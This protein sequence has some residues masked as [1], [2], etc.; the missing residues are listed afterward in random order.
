MIVT[1]PK[2]EQCSRC[3][4]D[5]TDIVVRIT[6]PEYNDILLHERCE[7]YFIMDMSLREIWNED[8]YPITY[9]TRKQV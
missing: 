1:H 9:L 5:I 6:S 8:I 7:K 3:N 4:L 2:Y